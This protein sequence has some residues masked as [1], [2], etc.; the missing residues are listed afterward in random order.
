MIQDHELQQLIDAGEHWKAKEKLQGRMSVPGYDCTLLE[1]YGNVLLAMNDKLEAGRYLFLSGARKQYYSE[2][3]ELY[4]QRYAGKN[5][6][7]IFHTFPKN[8]QCA[9]YSEFP[10]IVKSELQELKFQPKEIKSNLNKRQYKKTPKDRAFEL[11]CLAIVIMLLIAFLVGVG[12][13]IGVI[14]SKF[15]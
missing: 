4:L 12:N 8:V 14:W 7:H 5:T 13:G 3:I 9:A 11:G 2:C 10:E 1:E 15:T 6:E